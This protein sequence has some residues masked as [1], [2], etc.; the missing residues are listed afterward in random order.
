MTPGIAPTGISYDRMHISGSMIRTSVWWEVIEGVVYD[1]AT[2]IS[3]D[4]KSLSYLQIIDTGELIIR[5]IV[6]VPGNL[7]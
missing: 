5:N 3:R 1:V 7:G 6:L 2:L 4:D